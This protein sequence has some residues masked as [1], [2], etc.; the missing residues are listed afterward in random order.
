MGELTRR[1][2]RHSMSCWGDS[3]PMTSHTVNWRWWERNRSHSDNCPSSTSKSPWRPITSLIISLSHRSC[4][5]NH[6]TAR[7][8]RTLLQACQRSI[9]HC[10]FSLQA[11]CW[12][13]SLE[14]TRLSGLVDVGTSQAPSH[15]TG[16]VINQVV[17]HA[18]AQMESVLLALTDIW[19]GCLLRVAPIKAALVN[20]P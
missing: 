18:V 17:C 15:R 9:L 11:I 6:L 10:G 12:N 14:L 2:G 16:R 1:R 8:L 5:S 20:F 19:M 7:A 3:V 4:F 13:L